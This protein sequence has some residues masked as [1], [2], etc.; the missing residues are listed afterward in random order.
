MIKPNLVRLG[1]K[2]TQTYYISMPLLGVPRQSDSSPTKV[3]PF[4]YTNQAF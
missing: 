2:Y 1:A 3:G 4:F